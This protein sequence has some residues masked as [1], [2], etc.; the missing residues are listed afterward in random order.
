MPN[1]R[2]VPV[3]AIDADIAVLSASP[4]LASTMPVSNLQLIARDRVARSTSL[5]SQVISG[6]WSGSIKAVNCWG[7]FRHNLLGAQVRLQLYGDVALTSQIYD[8]GAVDV[9]TG[10]PLWGDFKWGEV[11]WG[12]AANDPLAGEA[13]YF[14]FLSSTY[15]AAGFKLT[16]SNPGGMSAS[17]FELSR[18]WLGEYLEAPYNPAYGKQ[19]GWESSTQPGRTRGG[20]QRPLAG[21]RWRTLKIDLTQATEADR[22]TWLDL[23]ARLDMYKPC[24]VS[25]HPNLG[26]RGE[27]DNTLEALL[28]SLAPQAHEEPVVW[29]QS[30]TFKET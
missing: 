12:V 4:A 28:E 2:I 14:K 27:R 13:P 21:E 15:Y 5:A 16:I 10:A 17:Y 6:T 19:L 11:P 3:N 22:G 25:V 7:I 1:L 9:Y 20:S 24:V 26:G 29:T 30:M 18:L 23:S 8:S